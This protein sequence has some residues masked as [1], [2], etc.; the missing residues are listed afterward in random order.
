MNTFNGFYP[1]RRWIYVLF[2][3]LAITLTIGLI[4][5]IPI[6]QLSGSIIVTSMLVISA[7]IFKKLS[8]RNS[9]PNGEDDAH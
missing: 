9:S 6:T 1:I 3:I 8:L 5:K 7:V 2:L 4:F